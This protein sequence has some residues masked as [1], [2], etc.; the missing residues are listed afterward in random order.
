MKVGL[1]QTDECRHCGEAEESPEHI[2]LNCPAMSK[3]SI[4]IDC[5]LDSSNKLLDGCSTN[6]SLSQ[7]KYGNSMQYTRNGLYNVAAY[8]DSKAMLAQRNL[9]SVASTRT[10]ATAIWW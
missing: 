3:N 2:R 6:M 4:N 1:S 5:Y 8:S 7:D 10:V 9:Q